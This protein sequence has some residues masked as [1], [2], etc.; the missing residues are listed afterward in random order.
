[1]NFFN[2]L[3]EQSVKLVCQDCTKKKT[4]CVQKEKDFIICDVYIIIKGK[5]KNQTSI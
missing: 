1:M 4:H 2:G 5:K 3:L